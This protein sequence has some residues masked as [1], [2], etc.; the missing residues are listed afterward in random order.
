MSHLI[1]KPW[2]TEQVIY[3]QG[4]VTIKIIRIYDGEELS[5]Q[6]HNYKVETLWLLS[7]EAKALV[8]DTYVNFVKGQALHIEKKIPHRFIGIRKAEL[9][10]VSIGND[11]DI[12]RL[13]DKYGRITNA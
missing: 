6:Y 12:V 11:D 3:R 13:K 10:E 4:D 1:V 2:G 8:V 9:L 7:G 5:L